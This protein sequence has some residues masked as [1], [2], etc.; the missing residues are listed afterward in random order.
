VEAFSGTSTATL[1]PYLSKRRDDCRCKEGGGDVVDRVH[2][3]AAE[4]EGDPVD[5]VA[6]LGDDL[7]EVLQRVPL[8]GRRHVLRRH[9]DPDRVAVGPTV[10]LKCRTALI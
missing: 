9:G 4:D 2:D 7:G 10:A 8:L 6:N 1:N 3:W 5:V